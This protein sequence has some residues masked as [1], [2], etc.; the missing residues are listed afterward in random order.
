[1]LQ[2]RSGECRRQVDLD[3]EVFDVW[4]RQPGGV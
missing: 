3:V 1:M 4:D 2:Q